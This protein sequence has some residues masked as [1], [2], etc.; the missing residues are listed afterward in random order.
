M[1]RIGLID[2]HI[3]LIVAECRAGEL[4]AMLVSALHGTPHW[5]LHAAEVGARHRGPRAA[6]VRHAALREVDERKRAAEQMQD[7]VNG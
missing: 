4:F 3:A 5:R 6:G 1:N 2:D 7:L